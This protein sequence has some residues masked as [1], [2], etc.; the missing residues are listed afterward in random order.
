[1]AT[2]KGN[3]RDNNISG[4]NNDDVIR[5]YGGDG[6]DDLTGEDGNDSL[7]G[8]A[9]DDDLDGGL[10]DDFLAGGD[11]DD[12]L[13]GGGG[14]DILFGGDGRDWLGGSEA[15]PAQRDELHGEEGNDVLFGNEADILR[16]GIG[17]DTYEITSS[18]AVPTIVELASEGSAD[19]VV[20]SGSFDLALAPNV[21]NLFCEGS[22][23]GNEL[24]NVI[25]GPYD[26]SD[27]GDPLTLD[28]R[29]G[30]DHLVGNI[31]ASNTYTGGAGRDT[32]YQTATWDAD[33][34]FFEREI[35][36]DFEAGHDL[37]GVMWDVDAP[38]RY[39][40]ESA[41]H[42]GSG[43]DAV[44]QTA[45][46]RYI[47]NEDSGMLYYDPD[48]TG[49]NGMRVIMEIHVLSGQLSHNDFY[50]VPTVVDFPPE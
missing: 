23:Y 7:H 10:G 43:A 9:G 27:E 40:D 3:S 11:G 35:I 1:M 13:T 42:S 37:I 34:S 32:F 30:D 44:A 21:E 6:R 15:G 48:G 39:I 4:T 28:G 49:A 5:G 14:A 20:A 47:Y 41:F 36:L 19:A 38:T 50:R 12:D 2:K 16:G 25:R 29:G 18:S 8:E 24:D 45:A 17:D 26:G 22:G 31:F 33:D 46:H